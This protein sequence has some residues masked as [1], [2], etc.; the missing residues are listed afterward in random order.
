M[1]W[2][3]NMHDK[4]ERIYHSVI[5]HGPHND[6][7][8]VM[9]LA[10]QDLPII[11][12]YVDK[13]AKQ[14]RY[15]KIFA[16]VPAWAVSTATKKGYHCEAFIPKFFNGT[17]D[18][19]F[20]GKYFNEKRKIID[21]KS[22][23]KIEQIKKTF[24]K[25]KTRSFSADIPNDIDIEQI[26]NE[27]VDSLAKLYDSVFS[28]Y[29]F[30]IHKQSYLEKMLEH[31]VNYYGI[32]QQGRLVAA[33]AAEMEKEHSFVEM[34]DFATLPSFRGNNYAFYL[35]QFMEKEMKKEK[36]STAFTIARAV[37]YGM[38]I[39]FAKAAY[40][41]AGLLKNNTA[42]AGSLESMNVL[43]KKIAR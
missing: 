33:S 20:L 35:L 26:T 24:Q 16:K 27:N 28:S 41:Y 15:S 2:Y 3:S 40:C 4:V 37:S 36:M 1:F 12:D 31:D 19:Y 14:N 9:K 8:Y 29:P 39:T 17:T 32:F 18:G 25:Y 42:I 13:L 34:T 30:P 11:F 6:R 5:Q 38:N 23:K 43:Y 10:K 22:E 7:V 21:E